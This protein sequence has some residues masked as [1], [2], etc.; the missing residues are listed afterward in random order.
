MPLKRLAGAAMVVVL[1]IAGIDAAGPDLRVVEAVRTRHTGIVA[2]LL[3]QGADVNA[4]QGDGAT[5]LHWAVYWDDAETAARLIG[6]G[7]RVNATT[8]LG[9][10][11]LSVASVHGAA[12]LVQTLLEAGADPNAALPS[13]ETALMTASRTG[14]VEAV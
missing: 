7:A 4:A 8:D 10:T 13:G 5:A 3:R 6:A 2:T 12:G 11:P 1:G 9:A 14:S